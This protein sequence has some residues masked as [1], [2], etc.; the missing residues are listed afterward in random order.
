MNKFTQ[1]SL[2]FSVLLWVLLLRMSA[3]AMPASKSLAFQSSVVH[4][5]HQVP[6]DDTVNLDE[7]FRNI[8]DY[9]NEVFY[10]VG[11]IS[12]VKYRP[13]G[14]ADALIVKIRGDS[15]QP[16]Q[17]Y[18]YVDIEHVLPE[19]V[20]E[21][22]IVQFTGQVMGFE[23]YESRPVPA[24]LLMEYLGRLQ[25]EGDPPTCVEV[26]APTPT[27]TLTFQ[28]RYSAPVRSGPNFEYHI[29]G[30]K[31]QGDPVEPIA[32]TTDGRWLKLGEGQWI[33]AFMLEGN[34]EFLPIATRPPTPTPTP[35]TRAT[36]TPTPPPTPRITVTLTPTPTPQ[37]EDSEEVDD[38]T[39]TEALTYIEQGVA[40]H[41]LGQYEE[42][43]TAYDA[44]LR[45]DPGNVEALINRGAA[46]AELNRHS[47]AI[48]DYN[49]ALALDPDHGVA[50]ANRAYAQIVLGRYEGAIVDYDAVLRQDP[51]NVW[52]L[53]NRGWVKAR[54]GRYEEAIADYDAA[55]ALDPNNAM[56][57]NNREQARVQMAQGS[58]ATANSNANLRAGPGTQ[59]PIVGNVQKGDRV[60]PVA[61]S[62]SGQWL[63]LDSG[64]WIYAPLVDNIP[65]GLATSQRVLPTPVPTVE[66][67]NQSPYGQVRVEQDAS[68]WQRP[69]AHS[70]LV[71]HLRQGAILNACEYRSPW[72][73]I[74]GEGWVHH[75]YV[76]A[77][78]SATPTPT[79]IPQPATPTPTPALNPAHYCP[80]VGDIV[81]EYWADRESLVQR[82]Q[83]TTVCIVGLAWWISEFENQFSIDLLPSNV[84]GPE[85]RG[86][87]PETSLRN[88]KQRDDS[89]WCNIDGTDMDADTARILGEINIDY[90]AQDTTAEDLRRVNILLVSGRMNIEY[91]LSAYRLS[92]KDCQIHEVLLEV[93]PD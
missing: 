91:L 70:G 31:E 90:E 11:E 69:Q 43:V 75:D 32:Q 9:I 59:Y 89:V 57:Q 83:D 23:E 6:S 53:N 63:Q 36:F 20:L 55:L 41:K 48:A 27:P 46:K 14:H 30:R 18:L 72:V 58:G 79:P 17:P 76:E 37:P 19:R 12:Y 5:Q 67:Y 92:L 16:S 44:A 13:N 77:Y 28:M 24:V 84:L 54:L 39:L 71:G 45:L 2:I 65:P 15:L 42:A 7:L 81:A 35:R 62:G 4:A 86:W 64:Y 68:L 8:E 29:V 56:A 85:P 47:E 82:R 40:K 52:A 51:D 49:A 34:K 73:Y 26:M 88:L 93:P 38:A 74:C 33:L 21:G 61:Q 60:R 1:K 87:W 3:A 22:D 66:T 80:D 78:P 25:C 10:F 50:L